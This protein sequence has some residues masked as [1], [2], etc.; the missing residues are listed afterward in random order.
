MVLNCFA[1]TGLASGNQA[2]PLST[3]CVNHDENATE[4]IHSQRHET[5][6]TFGIR[7]FDRESQRIAKRLFSVCKADTM[8]PKIAPGLD[9]VELEGHATLCIQH[10]YRQSTAWFHQTAEV[11]LRFP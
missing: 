1:A 5:S 6:L 10:A 8:L 3:L 9:G 7:V 11:L 4:G 2:R